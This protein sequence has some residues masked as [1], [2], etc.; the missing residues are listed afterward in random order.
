MKEN[1]LTFKS[2]N[3]Q[4]HYLTLNMQF[5]DLKRIKKIADYFSNTF[6]CNSTFIDCKNSTQNCTLIKKEKSLCKAEFRVNFQKYWYGTSLSF[7]GNQSTYFYKIIKGKRLDWE[8]LDFDNTN[9]SRIDLYYDR[10][11]KKGDEIENFDSFLK[12]C[13]SQ[14]EKVDKRKKVII[15]KGVLRV[16][17]RGSGNYFR[18]YRRPNGKD[19]RFELEL[20]K[21]V[22]KNFEFYLFSNQFEKLEELLCV[23]FYKQALTTFVMDSCY[24][25]WLRESFRKIRSTQTYENCLITTYLSKIPLETME[26]Q[27]FL[28]QLLQL[29]SYIR[30]LESSVNW[31]SNEN[32]RI[33]SFRVSEFL[34]F[35]G[36]KKTN[37]YQ[38]RKVVDFLKSLQRLPPVLE[39]FSTES[40][41]SILIFP[42]LEV[43]KE[44]SWKVE[45]AIAEK[46][47]FY[48]YPFYFPQEFLT[49]DDAYDLRAKIFF[50]L[51]FS[52]TKLDKEFQIQEI[53][54]QFGISRQK[55]TR[56]RKS[57]VVI[58]ED[59]QDLKLIE[60][61]FTLLMKTNK[62]K[63]VDKLTSNLLVKAK[64]IFYTE[65]P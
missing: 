59:A 30:T 38:I 32:Y 46:V 37:Y 49:Y 24:T 56:L 16:G 63:E 35:L 4:I 51:S 31:I 50:L 14:I 21:S 57:I 12:E 34:E 19:I 40:F 26:K 36:K 52:T 9:L 48:R 42:Y 60:P 7:S 29:L 15:D 1:R 65:I 64:S 17:R 61:R 41:R 44:K 27:K 20:T 10:K 11:F 5:D 2:E 53:F 45:L 13:R 54:D 33:I 43:R 55:M 39:D 47:Y 18:V 23:H 62:T 28:Y 22:V 8:I 3:F 6:D 25:D 58:F